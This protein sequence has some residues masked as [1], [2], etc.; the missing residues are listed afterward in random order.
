[1]NILTFDIEEWF[2]LLDFDATRT[3]AEWKNYEVRIH[4][5]VE[6]IFRI[7]EETDTK[8]TF[9]IIGWI[10]KTYPEL[11]RKIADKYQIGC[12]TMNHQLVWQQ[13]PEEFRADVE[14]GVKMLEDITGKKVECFRAPGFS[15]RESEGWAYEILA[16]L[17]IRYDC[18]VF[19]AAHA[20]GGMPSYPKPAPGIIEYKGIQIKEFPVSFK[21]IA[22]K[23]IIF[24]GGG[25]FRL[26]PYPM[27]RRWSR[28]ASDYLM[29]YIHPRDL[30]AGQPM[31]EG[32]PATRKFKSY[33]GLK[34]AEKKLRKWLTE[35]EF[36]DVAAAERQVDWAKVPVVKV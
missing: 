7:L 34:G 18:S 3:E 11:V 30:D 5:N 1:M 32:L 12:H 13:T 31:L 28:E 4:E 36:G 17:G 20:H 26:C 21:T 24:S 25:Y 33:V 35:F 22:G 10:A 15:I 6:R 19:P 14:T 23:H 29:A 16:D 27:V 2:H 8:A 9:F